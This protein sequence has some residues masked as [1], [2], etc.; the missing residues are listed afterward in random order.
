M[1]LDKSTEREIEG[2]WHTSRK[3]QKEDSSIDDMVF[4][5]SKPTLNLGMQVIGEI[6]TILQA[7]THI[8]EVISSPGSLENKR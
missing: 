8:L 5:T 6:V 2:F 7:I 3:P 1:N 4:S